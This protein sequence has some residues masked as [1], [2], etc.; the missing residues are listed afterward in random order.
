MV[1]DLLHPVLGQQPTTTARVTR[2]TASLTLL[3]PVLA[4]QL[5]RF[6]P[7]LRATLLTRLRR[8]RRRRRGTGTRTRGRFLLQHAQPLLQPQLPIH[9]P[10]QELDA[11]LPTRV[12]DRLRLGPLHTDKV[13][14]PP[15]RTLL[16]KARRT[17]RLP[18]RG[19][20]R[21]GSGH[22]QALARLVTGL[23]RPRGSPARVGG[24]RGSRPPASGPALLPRQPPAGSRADRVHLARRAGSRSARRARRLHASRPRS[25]P[26]RDARGREPVHDRVRRR[27]L[28]PARAT[29]PGQ[30]PDHRLAR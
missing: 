8:I 30:R 14:R 5:L 13:R 25:S 26:A 21:P 24:P 20:A 10:H 22:P 23:R 28:R 29:R 7:R 2:L 19:R 27:P 17:E 12:I 3:L 6:L 4:R 11:R 18:S 1:N 15:E 9:Q 16:W